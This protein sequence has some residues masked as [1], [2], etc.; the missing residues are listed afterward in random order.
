M[1]Y[2]EDMFSLRG[3]V[4]VITGAARGN[5]RAIAEALLRSG[6]EII[7][8]DVLKKEIEE[9]VAYLRQPGSP[10]IYNYTC[11]LSDDQQ[12]TL[13]LNEI[14]K[15]G[16][17]DVLVNNAGIT[18]GNDLFDY[19]LEDWRKTLKINLEVPFLLSQSIG[20]IMSRQQSG[21][22]INITSLNAELGFS[23]N[24]AYASS[25]GGLKQLSKSLAMDLGKYGVR[26]NSVSPG[27]FKTDMT[28]KSWGDPV[29][30]DA[31]TNRTILGR[32]GEP[33]DLAG[34]VVFLASP[35]SSYITGQ[36]IYVDGGW[37]AKGI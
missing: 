35:A 1:S 14:E 10:K 6:S 9:T 5:G 17:V 30:R 32:W 33:I 29:S 36:D 4:S 34:A 20:K 25:K 19:T 24:P 21:S 12:F 2:V 13:F 7:V 16:R 11:D 28:K 31:R 26:V 8:C 22:I 23:N 3:K 18:K 15:I 27:Y 37:L